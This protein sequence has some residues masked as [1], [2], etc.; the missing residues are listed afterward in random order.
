MSKRQF[1][2]R[3]LANL[4]GIYWQEEAWDKVVRVIDRILVLTPEAG[5]EGE[6]GV[7]CH[8]RR[9]GGGWPTGSATSR[10]FPTRPTGNRRGQ[11]SG[12]SAK[13]SPASTSGPE[14]TLMRVQGGMNLYGYSVGILV[15]DTRF[16][17]MP[18]DI[19][20]AGTFDFPVRYHRVAGASSE[21]V[22]R[23]NQGD[24]LP[25]FVEGARAL[26][27]EGVRAITTSCGFLASHQAELAAA[28][29]VPVFTSSL[30]LVPLVR[31]ML[32]PGPRGGHHDRRRLEPR[33]RRADRRRH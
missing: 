28:V 17:R 9:S 12:E 22:V 8:S 15:L 7:A 33:R 19:G 10:T 14:E 23:G 3:M 6:M 1:L 30:L 29:R 16:P 24:L 31:R 5:S 21:G 25:L 11:S 2:G 20:N 26:E 13:S 32:P 27:R 18:G 4:K